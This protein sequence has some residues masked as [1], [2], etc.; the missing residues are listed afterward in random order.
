MLPLI[1]SRWATA[2]GLIGRAQAQNTQFTYNVHGAVVIAL[3]GERTPLVSETVK[4]TSLG[5]QQMFRNV[6]TFE[7]TYIKRLL[8][9]L[10]LMLILCQL[11]ALVLNVVALFVEYFVGIATLSQLV[12]YVRGLSPALTRKEHISPLV[13]SVI[14]C[15]ILLTSTL[16]LCSERTLTRLLTRASSSVIAT[17]IPRQTPITLTMHQFPVSKGA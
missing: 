3:S 12:A 10:P 1:F 7:T 14:I 9:N 2:I 16:L 17:S 8:P 6:R 5:A 15:G 4:L 13:G 11:I